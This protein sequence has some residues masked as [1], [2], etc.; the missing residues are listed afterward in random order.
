MKCSH[1]GEREA[2]CIGRYDNMTKREPACDE[3]CGHGCED[4]RCD[5]IP[6]ADCPNCAGKTV[7]F[8]GQGLETTYRLCSRWKEPGHL[9]QDEAMA[10]VRRVRLA[11]MPRSGRS[12]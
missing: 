9:S 3:C 4:G 10:Q 11:N 2:T 8:Q 7:D 12:A 6:A 5:P 1:C